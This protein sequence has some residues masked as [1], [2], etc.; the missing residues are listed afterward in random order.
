MSCFASSITTLLWYNN[1]ITP[2]QCCCLCCA[3]H[4]FDSGKIAQIASTKQKQNTEDE[5][6]KEK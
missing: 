6:E 5:T 1:I 2:L 3:T 4:I